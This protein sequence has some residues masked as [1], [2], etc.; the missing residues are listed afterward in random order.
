MSSWKSPLKFHINF[1]IPDVHFAD[2]FLLFSTLLFMSLYNICSREGK[3]EEDF[4]E[5]VM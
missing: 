4:K 1:F 2:A 3:S 5:A